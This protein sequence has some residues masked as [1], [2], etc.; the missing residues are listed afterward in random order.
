MLVVLAAI[1]TPQGTTL[2][3]IAERTGLDK[4]TVTRLIAQAV[5]QA[6]VTIY[7]TGPVYEIGDWG[8]VVKRSGAK[9]ALKGALNA[10]TLKQ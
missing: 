4:K 5:E 8:P 3:R 6:G 1:D 2:V 7:K 9:L 10:P